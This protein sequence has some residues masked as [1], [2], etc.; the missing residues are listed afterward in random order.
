LTCFL[1]YPFLY[2]LVPTAMAEMTIIAAV[3][4]ALYGF[5]KLPGRARLWVGLFLPVLPFGLPL[6]PAAPFRDGPQARRPAGG[7]PRHRAPQ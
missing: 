3:L 4:L 5:T 7:L 6:S 1:G 2:I